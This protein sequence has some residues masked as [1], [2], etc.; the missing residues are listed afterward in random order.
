MKKLAT[1]TY[2][3]ISKSIILNLSIWISKRLQQEVWDYTLAKDSWWNPGEPIVRTYLVPEPLRQRRHVMWGGVVLWTLHTW[4]SNAFPCPCSWFMLFYVLV[5]SGFDIHL[6]LSWLSHMLISTASWPTAFDIWRM[7]AIL[8]LHPK[9][10][11]R[12]ELYQLRSGSLSSWLPL[13]STP[14]ISLLKFLQVWTWSWPA[15]ACSCMSPLRWALMHS[16]WGPVPQHS[17]L[18]Y[19]VYDILIYFGFYRYRCLC[20]PILTIIYKSDMRR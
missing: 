15:V 11:N 10:G 7:W 6:Q 9:A 2:H 20:M 12:M 1:L 19:I 13:P 5:H 8:T 4:F 18:Q 3:L 17:W 16:F 14:S